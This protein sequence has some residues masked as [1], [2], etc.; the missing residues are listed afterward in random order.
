MALDGGQRQLPD[1]QITSTTRVPNLPV[2]LN[3]IKIAS[4]KRLFRVL[5]LDTI[6]LVFKNILLGRGLYVIGRN[7]RTAFDIIESLCSL[8]YPLKWE[9]PKILSYESR[10]EIFESPI[11]LIYYFDIGNLDYDKLSR[12]DLSEKCILFADANAVREHCAIPGIKELPSKAASTLQKSLAKCVGH[13]SSYYSAKKATSTMADFDLLLE[14]ENESMT[15]DAWKV[16]EC[17]FDFMLELL[18]GYQD[19]FN[20]TQLICAQSLESSNIFDFHK[21]CKS[22]NSLKNPDFIMNF[23]KTSLFSRFLECRAHPENEQQVRYYN[24]FDYLQKE[25]KETPKLEL[26]AKFMDDLNKRPVLT[27]ISPSSARIEHGRTFNYDSEMPV[28]NQEYLVQPR[29]DVISTQGMAVEDDFE[30]ADADFLAKFNEEKW[31]KRNLEFLYTIWFTMLKVFMRDEVQHHYINLIT[32]AY[33]KLIQMEEDKLHPSIDT[34]KSMAYML[35]IFNEGNKLSRIMGKYAKVINANGQY[36]SVIVEYIRG[37]SVRK[38]PLQLAKKQVKFAFPES[39]TDNYTDAQLET[40]DIK[41]MDEEERDVTIPTSVRSYFETNAFCPQC[42]T[43]IPEEIIL[44]KMQRGLDKTRSVCPNLV[45]QREYE[46]VF[47]CIFLKQ[48]GSKKSQESVKLLS[49]IHLLTELK[50]YLR[51]NDPNSILDVGVINCSLIRQASY[52]GIFCSMATF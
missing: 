37:T 46:P 7:P 47:N 8:L 23:T 2:D 25:K 29:I 5:C 14:N 15:F 45:C 49:P 9:H 40:F 28:L 42:G 26:L 4:L 31:A 22:K 21:F 52:I 19:C 17:F 24:Y 12:M 41:Q 1:I 33:E 6:I 51:V 38:A 36:I 3:N 11:P 50:E 30:L 20:E 44:A 39:R 32:F 43:Y 13:Y 18:S 10:Y 27:T 48:Q 16:R 35:G 34:I